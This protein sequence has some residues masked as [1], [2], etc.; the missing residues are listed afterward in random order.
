MHRTWKK[1]KNEIRNKRTEKK[2][3]GI[4]F[5]HWGEN[6]V[7]S[8]SEATRTCRYLDSH[9]SSRLSFIGYLDR[10]PSVQFFNQAVFLSKRHS[11]VSLSHNE[12]SLM[13]LAWNTENKAVVVHGSTIFCN[14]FFHA[15]CRSERIHRECV[16]EKLNAE[17]YMGLIETRYLF[18]FIF[19]CTISSQL[20]NW[21]LILE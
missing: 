13:P 3:T 12:H 6:K 17:I 10:R 18:Y 4:D 2:L 1:R 20:S 8:D 14:S 19:G 21:P 5:S 9:P 11:S 15:P 16:Q 7:D